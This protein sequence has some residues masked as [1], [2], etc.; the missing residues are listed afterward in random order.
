MAIAAL[1][2]QAQEM[3]CLVMELGPRVHSH[4]P[5]YFHTAAMGLLDHSSPHPC[6][7]PFKGSPVSSWYLMCKQLKATFEAFSWPAQPPLKHPP[8][9]TFC[10]SLEM[11]T[12]LISAPG[13]HHSCSSL[14]QIFTPVLPP[15][16]TLLPFSTWP[17]SSLSVQVSQMLC[18][19]SQTRL[20][21]AI[22]HTSP[23]FD[24]SF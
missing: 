12:W 8:S 10:L 23:W 15:S 21:S 4:P 2:T 20:W 6:L 22:Q 24:S 3:R 13:E 14:S 7:K 17:T 1:G 5:S 11:R 9:P 18:L 19:A 16:C